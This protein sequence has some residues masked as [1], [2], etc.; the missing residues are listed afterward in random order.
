MK[1][2]EEIGKLK[3]LLVSIQKENIKKELQILKEL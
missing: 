2:R 1:K 3:I